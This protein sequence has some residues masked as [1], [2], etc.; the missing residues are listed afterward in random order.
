M[1][2]GSSPGELLRS[3]LPDLCAAGTVA[4]F[5]TTSAKPARLTASPGF[6]SGALALAV[7]GGGEELEATTCWGASTESL[8][9]VRPREVTKSAIWTI[10]S[11]SQG[12]ELSLWGGA[13]SGVPLGES[14]STRELLPPPPIC[15]SPRNRAEHVARA[16]LYPPDPAD[17]SGFSHDRTLSA[18]ASSELGV[19]RFEPGI[20]HG[21]GFSPMIIC[22]PSSAKL[23]TKCTRDEMH[24]RSAHG[25]VCSQLCWE[26]FG[27]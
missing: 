7:G 3:E 5:A 8:G 27:L 20:D 4:V 18:A 13:A 9:K 16:L 17:V 26:M 12:L 22:Y 19:A 11:L 2:G 23:S 15:D 25:T 6:G 14:A 1:R 21:A 24:A 10:P